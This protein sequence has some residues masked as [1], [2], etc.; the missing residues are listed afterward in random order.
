MPYSSKLTRVRFIKLV[1]FTELR[2]WG[3]DGGFYILEIKNLAIFCKKKNQ[4]IIKL[5][6]IFVH[7]WQKSEV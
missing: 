5:R 1:T 6:I 4:I 7:K 2:K 3:H